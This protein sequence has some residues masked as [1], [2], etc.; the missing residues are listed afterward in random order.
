MTLALGWRREPFARLFLLV[1]AVVGF[2][3]AAKWVSFPFMPARLLWLLPWL[4]MLVV[5]GAAEACASHA[6]RSP[7]G[8]FCSVRSG[9]LRAARAS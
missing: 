2:L 5:S 7:L 6:S 4:L 9:A 3:G 8:W 1:A